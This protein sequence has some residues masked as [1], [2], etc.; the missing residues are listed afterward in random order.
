MKIR[1]M[2]NGKRQMAN[3][4]IF[5]IADLVGRSAWSVERETG[6]GSIGQWAVGIK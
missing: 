6:K 1:D 5:R 2:V 4:K 3:V